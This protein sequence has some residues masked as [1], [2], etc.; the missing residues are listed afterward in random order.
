MKTTIKN[1]GIEQ[2]ILAAVEETQGL[3]ALDKERLE[4]LKSL[5]QD[6]VEVEN[7]RLENM[8]FPFKK[9]LEATK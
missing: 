8:L 5:P 3:E 2:A 7:N 1:G 4:Y 6:R 9:L